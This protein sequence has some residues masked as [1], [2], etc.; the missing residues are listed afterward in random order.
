MGR[1]P[2]VVFFLCS[3][4]FSS[5]FKAD[6]GLATDILRENVVAGSTLISS[7]LIRAKSPSFRLLRL[8]GKHSGTLTILLLLSGNVERNPGPK[9]PKYPCSMCSRAVK[10]RDPAV[11]CDQCGLWVHNQCSGLSE[12]MYERMK[13]SCGVW[14]CPSCGMPSFTSSFFD[15]PSIEISNSFSSLTDVND[16]IE[17]PRIASTPVKC[18][19]PLKSEKLRKREKLKVISINVNG[20][21]SKKLQLCELIHAEKPDILLCQETKV[22]DSVSSIELFPESFTVFRKDRNMNGG[23]VC[24]AVRKELQAMH[25][26]DLNVANLEAIWVQL[27]TS[28]HQPLYICS[29]YRPNN[30][31]IELLRKPLESLSRRHH[32]R[33]P[34][35][36]VAGDLNYPQIDW[37]TESTVDG[38]CNAFLDVLN[39]FHLHQLVS[40]PTRFGSTASSVLDLVISSHP[41]AMDNVVVGSEF[42]D[43]CTVSFDI[44]LT[45]VTV[46]NHSR[47]IFLYNKG[48]F[49]Q[50]CASLSNFSSSFF[51]SSPDS[52]SVN[53]NWLQ[54]KQAITSAIEKHIPSKTVG[55]RNKKP[56][57]LNVAVRRCIRK[58]NKLAKV[59]KQTGSP[60]DRARFRKAR[61]AAS[62]NIETAY[63]EHLNGVIGDVKSDPRAFY[64]FIKSK[65]TDP[66]GISCLRSG[67]DVLLADIDKANCLNNY[68]A[69]VFTVESIAA[70]PIKGNST[71]SMPDI[72]VTSPGVLKLLVNLDVK[73]STGP[74]GI[75]PFV[76]K[77]ACHVIVDVLTFIFN[78]SLSS[79]SVPDDWRLAN[80]FPLHK[81]GA[82]DAAENYRPISLT[83]VCSKLLEHIVYSSMCKFLEENN[84]LTP[85]QHGFRPGFSC[86]TQLTAAIDDWARALN[87]GIRTDIAIFDFSKAFDSVPHRR[88]KEKIK[89]YGIGGKTL[90]WIT[91][92]LSNRQQR[93][94]LSGGQS[95]WL[96][97]VSGVPQG[98]V[99]GPLLFLLYINDITSDISSEIRLFADDCILYRQIRQP[100]DCSILQSDIDKLHGWS[101]I[102]QMTFNSKK[103]HILSVSRQRKKP[104]LHYTLGQDLLTVVDSYPYLGVTISNDLRWHQHIDNISAKATRT[105][106]F[107]R[108]NVYCCSPEAKSLAFI[109]LIR[110]HLEYAAA[111]WDPYT[112]RDSGQLDNVQRRAARFVKNDYRRTT[113]VSQ[114]VA[115]LGWDSLSDRRKTARLSLF[116]KGLHGLAA[117]PVDQLKP[118]SRCT[119]H[120]STNTFHSLS[121]RIDCYKNSFLPRTVVDWNALP[122]DVRL[123]PSVDSFRAAVHGLSCRRS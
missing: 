28:D 34:F 83:S 6:C 35:I 54:L 62:R 3:R 122:D 52:R 46:N 67:G 2:L 123:R 20:L 101:Q 68:F 75:S 39:D 70:V 64:R 84:I 59:A 37:S 107:V 53:D 106:N 16:D 27:I 55:A 15:S 113:S 95:S 56:P 66:V 13:Q 89:S 119:R 11:S 19:S 50:L 92:F 29:V 82:K 65:R 63:R 79:G 60:I 26:L 104:L 58:R 23:G 7:G 22:D 30:D 118:S 5:V 111:A 42:S 85:R 76:L 38:S 32:S 33:P 97:V 48:D 115:Q 72:Q 81:K 8:S 77:E 108:R 57:W 114:L 25:C 116:Y 74:D 73:K 90:S 87:S 103:C 96:P 121:A 12:H 47:K 94:V 1:F 10:N 102:W 86:E 98:T 4:C 99:L 93:V 109:S 36:V 61:N 45:P 44:L 49:V 117:V 69:S 91:S 41:A 17:V 100:A 110:P 120:S 21:R 88:L 80:I 24:I 40:T 78:Q 18:M 71:P 105:L 112:A 51:K 9:Q 43:H 14:I 31:D